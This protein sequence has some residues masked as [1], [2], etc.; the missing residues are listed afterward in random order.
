MHC[1]EEKKEEQQR[2]VGA[3]GK[4]IKLAKQAENPVERL[5]HVTVLLVSFRPAFNH[6]ERG[7]EEQKWNDTLRTREMEIFNEYGHQLVKSII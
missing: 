7:K 1:S 6:F 5:E 4:W 2:H 3:G